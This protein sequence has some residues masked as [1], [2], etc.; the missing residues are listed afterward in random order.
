VTLIQ[1]GS[2]ASL[3]AKTALLVLGVH[4]SG[5]SAFTRV[6]NLLGADL[7]SH[8]LPETPN[9]PRGFWESAEVVNIHEEILATAATSWDDWRRFNPAWYESPLAKIYK[10]RLLSWLARDFGASAF[11]VIKDPRMC[12]L[13]PLWRDTLREF[14]AQVK[15]VIPIRNP[16]E[17][18]ASLESRDGFTPVKSYLIWLRHMLDALRDSAGLP[19]CVVSYDALLSDWRLTTTRIARCLDVT[20]PRSS[21]AVDSQID[22]FLSARDRH[23][24]V[25]GGEWL[26]RP[27]IADWVKRGYRELLAM[28]AHG[29]S[30]SAQT[31]LD[32]L[33]VEFDAAIDV[34]GPVLKE[35]KETA[36]LAEV[37]RESVAREVDRQRAWQTVKEYQDAI[38]ALQAEHATRLEQLFQEGRTREDDRLAAWRTVEGLNVRLAAVQEELERSRAE[39]AAREVDRQRAWQA[40][41]EYQDASTALQA[42][43][44]ARLEQLFREAQ[45][46]EDDRLS[47]RQR[48]ER[49]E[50]QLADV[51]QERARTE[52]ELRR[53]ALSAAQTLEAERAG[54]DARVQ[55]VERALVA[56][57]ARQLQAQAELHAR[58]LATQVRDLTVRT[59]SG[60]RT[61]DTVWRSRSWRFTAPLRTVMR[62]VRAARA[63]LRQKADR[64]IEWRP[65]EWLHRRRLESRSAL[66]RPPQTT[67]ATSEIAQA[68]GV[69]A[70]S[71]VQRVPLTTQP[72]LRNPV[73][74][75]IAFYLPQFHP[76]P[77]NDEWWGKGFTEWN[78]VTRGTP[79]FVGHYQP[80]LPGELGFYDLRV[81]DVQRRQV[82]LA[83]LYG[84]GA[85]C[86]YF[87]WFSGKRL[88]E[89]PLQGYLQDQSLDLPFCLC[90]ANE[91]WTRRWDGTDHEVL[92]AQHHSP[93][94]DLAFIAHV[95]R[96]FQDAR[97][98]RVGG[99]PLL[100]VYRPKLLPSARATAERWREWCRAHGIGEI[101][102][103]YTQSF[104]TVDPEEY[105]FDAAIEFP[106]N[107]SRPP[108]IRDEVQLLSPDFAGSI[109][110]W[111]IFVKRSREYAR[112]L[113]YTLFRGVT[114]SWD[115]EARRPGAGVVF[116][117]SSPAGYREW[118]TNAALDTYRWCQRSDERLVFVNAWN[119]WAEGTHLE[120]D[121]RYGYAYLQ[122]T[123]DALEAAAAAIDQRRV[124]IVAHDAYPHGSQYLA[125]H[126]ARGFSV[127]LKCSVDM[128]VLGD[129]PLKREFAEYATVHD[130]TGVDPEGPE[131]RNL[132]AR[133]FAAG[134]RAALCNTTVSA[135][136]LSTLKR[137]G[138]RCVSLIHEMSGVVTG[139]RLESHVQRIAS[140]ADIVVFP[141]RA[142][143]DG[144]ERFAVVPQDRVVIRPQGLYKRNAYSTGGRRAEARAALREQLGLPHTARI[145]LGVGFADHRKG[146]DLFVEA[147]RRILPDDPDVWF[148]WLGHRDQSLWP[149]VVD[150]VRQTGASDR[151]LFLPRDPV[152][153][154]YYAGADVYALT[155]REDPFP[156]VVLESL[157]VEVPVVAFAGTGGCC[158]LLEQGCGLL[159]P[160]FDTEA[161]AGAIRLLLNDEP[162]ARRLGL[163]GRR[164]VLDEFSFRRYLFELARW[165]DVPLRRVSVVVPNY[166][167][168][169]FLP[170][171]LRSIARQTYPVFELIVLDD[172]STDD[173]GERLRE[174]LPL[175]GIEYT[176]VVNERNSASA[177]RQWRKGVDL[178][179]GELVWIAEA[180]DVGDDGF[181]AAAV[182]SFAQ[183][184]SVVM[185]YCQSR[186]MGTDGTI[187]SEHYLDY[188]A[189]ISSTK[190][191]EP[192]IEDGIAEIRT[193]LAVK[194]TIP[195]VSAVVFSRGALR[196]ALQAVERELT[197]YR[198]AGDWL[199]YLEVLKR[200]RIAFVPQS[201]NSHRRHGSSVTLSSFDI[202]HLREIVEVQRTV[203]RTFQPEDAVLAIADAYAQALFVQFGLSATA[204]PRI[205]QHPQLA[206][207]FNGVAD[208]S[209]EATRRRSSFREHHGESMANSGPPSLASWLETMLE[210][211]RESVVE[212]PFGDRLPKFPDPQRQAQ[213]T[214]LSGPATVRQA[215][216][217]YEDI[218]HAAEE[219][220]LKW[221]AETRILDFGVGWGR[222]ARLFLRDVPLRNLWGLDVDPAFVELTQ[223]LFAG[224]NFSVCAPLPPTVLRAGHFD[225]VCA[226]SVFSHLSETACRLWT[227]EFARLLRPGGLFAFTTRHEDFFAYCEWAASLGQSAQGYVR[228]L[229][230]LF[231]D[232]EAV[233][234]T[235]RRGELVHATSPGVSGG[236]PRT[237]S[238]YGE[239]F[240]PRAYVERRLCAEFELIVSAYDPARYDQACFVLRRR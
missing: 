119:E 78:N 207:L 121:R 157:D 113:P 188:T 94:D 129:G 180:D 173:S 176:L 19:R 5:T 123:R 174:L 151:F 107:N 155:S 25:E 150:A 140:E 149:A 118:L 35:G 7:P 124:V 16:V 147:G 186:Q 109:V 84:I 43:H 168:A 206:P 56:E 26:G 83:K 44:A 164:R 219:C 75:L 125:L 8:L 30:Q 9:N 112:P 182:R 51:Q 197:H 4:R 110:D 42:E 154:L 23:H 193:A 218:Q 99:R 69:E 38:T 217:F 10:A 189:D 215:F 59:E 192:Y 97:Y 17:V 80:H 142:V 165:L 88:L 195:N 148:V 22:D 73:V 205:E 166:N 234:A 233:K 93:E 86:F 220:G 92:I 127:D 20:W 134:A 178:A 34:F 139:L 135:L 216:A 18:A 87:Y 31:A 33:A 27:E 79:Q 54:F 209:R 103:A 179:C 199:V 21:A 132:A 212:S 104:E 183:D 108:E 224:G 114:P 48:V 58:D 122:A 98:L 74:R 66:T 106:P 128:V 172:A 50:I 236:G 102:L 6:L 15:A 238:F 229:G 32:A 211:L 143:A 116:W 39:S 1:A 37:R 185:S 115:N 77:E 187:L 240:I 204:H 145:V 41:K 146:I 46:R 227:A 60:E 208:V 29:D 81:P 161:Y 95:A 156:A 45:A 210:S 163:E 198:V 177:A 40:V 194:N 235:Y 47:A 167:Y 201:L 117:G 237:E 214:G 36:V 105:G 65:F 64:V 63:R 3:V 55:A 12:R 131:A 221:S 159:A 13:V 223:D 203:R 200:G 202:E 61:M 111:R 137:A 68:I 53:A 169:G 82:E 231:P 49:L 138:F 76:I 226:Y 136:F 133:L 162:L 232:I 222:V 171:R 144:F 190:W 72:P 67:A 57:R 228:A 213:T 91:N 160:A 11:F 96:F 101:Y 120:P 170:E 239:T 126:V 153:D 191:R 52:D 90:W 225:L 14:G 100:L 71:G 196:A 184:P 62:H 175:L 230:E 85:F 70:R 24:V 2:S 181:L 130:L 141:A 158:E 89:A 28:T 152:T